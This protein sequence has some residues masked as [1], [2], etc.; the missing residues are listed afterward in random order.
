VTEQERAPSS[1]R[2]GG[3][4]A[5]R[6]GAGLQD[7]TAEVRGVQPHAAEQV[8][9]AAAGDRLASVVSALVDKVSRYAGWTSRWW[10]GAGRSPTP[11]TAEE[12]LQASEVAAGQGRSGAAHGRR[13]QRGP[14]G[15][16]TPAAAVS[17]RPALNRRWPQQAPVNSRFAANG[18]AQGRGCEAAPAGINVVVFA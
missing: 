18:A 7:P 16:S 15:P 14:P 13:T 10:T 5:G 3:L 9:I 17:P 12:S 6:E 1:L 4:L 11:C 2:R 8:P